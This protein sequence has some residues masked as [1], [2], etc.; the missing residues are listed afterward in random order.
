MMDRALHPRTSMR[1]IHFIGWL[2]PA[3]LV[4][5]VT[6]LGAC[7]VDLPDTLE[8]YRARTGRLTNA[9]ADAGQQPL[10]A[11]LSCPPKGESDGGGVSIVEVWSAP[12]PLH[13]SVCSP[14][15]A[16]ELVRCL[17]EDPLNATDQCK[18]FANG[19]E[20]AACLTCAVTPRS[21]PTWGAILRDSAQEPPWENV[22]GC[23]GSLSGDPSSHGCGAKL[24]AVDSCLNYVCR[25][26]GDANE[27]GKCADAALV[28]LCSGFKQ[29]ASC[30]DVHLPQCVPQSIATSRDL[31]RHMVRMFCEK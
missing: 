25:E 30:A 4:G 2:A 13:R 18:R 21:A 26:C 23:V 19:A 9:S 5:A 15:Q 29:E 1:G 24:L 22:E 11:T 10:A 28:T 27:F 20:N 16:D 3:W 8:E 12:A 31:G 6:I 14:Q 7:S 17:Y